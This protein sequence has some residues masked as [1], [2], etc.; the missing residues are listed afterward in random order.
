MKK[1]EIIVIT[2]NKMDAVFSLI[3]KNINIFL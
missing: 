3:Q 1:V 2:M